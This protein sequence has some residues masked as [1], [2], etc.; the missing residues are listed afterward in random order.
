MTGDVK[1]TPDNCDVRDQTAR[2]TSFSTYSASSLLAPSS[3]LYGYLLPLSSRYE[4]TS[5]TSKI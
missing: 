2:P 3:D 4:L 1:N 5:L